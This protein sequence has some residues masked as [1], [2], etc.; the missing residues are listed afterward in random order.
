MNK[1]EAWE[2]ISGAENKLAKRFKEIEDAALFNQEK[3]LNAFRNSNVELRHFASTTGYGHDDIGK[4]TLSRVFAD[5]FGAESAL[6]SPLITSGTHAISATLFGM[7]RS[8]DLLFSVTGNPYDTLMDTISGGD[9]SLKDFG[10]D[11]KCVDMLGDDVNYGEIEKSLRKLK[12]SVL[13][14]QRSRGYNWRKALTVEKIGEIIKF[15]RNFSNAPIVVDN[16]YGEFTDTIEPTEVGANVIV[17][18]LIKNAGG[19]LAPT[20]GYIAGDKA[21]VDK[22]A[23]RL[24]APGIGFE[25]GSYAYGYQY[26]YQGFFMAPH[27]VEQALKSSALFSC[28]LEGLGY[29]VTPRYSEKQS[30]IVTSIKFGDPDKLIEFCKA[31]QYNSPIDS[32][33]VPEP[34]EMAGYADK[35][36]MAAGAFVQGASIELSADAP[37]RTPYIAYLQGSLT[38]EHAKIALADV[39]TKIC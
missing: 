3:V 25:N 6:V 26:F 37:I 33:V 16:C 8:G 36:I 30:D 32:G 38:Y 12:P 31:I 15:L 34:W 39:L 11:F 20:G 2:L 1:N 5:A 4:N 29:E 27:T 23:N 22:I 21:Y 35:V 17:G 9:G 7:L 13:Y 10:I 18:S 14:I 24:T 19:G 28:V